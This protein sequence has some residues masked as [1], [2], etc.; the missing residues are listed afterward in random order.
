M[1]LQIQGLHYWNEH[2][3]KLRI[4]WIE[5]LLYSAKSF[6]KIIF[7]KTF[8]WFSKEREKSRSMKKITKQSLVTQE[9]SKIFFFLQIFQ[10]KIFSFL[11]HLPFFGPKVNIPIFKIKRLWK[12]W[13]SMKIPTTELGKVTFLYAEAKI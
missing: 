1:I 10:W 8:L 5:K 12:C 9:W 7:G 3:W 2:H 13:M 11:I 6:T 4:L